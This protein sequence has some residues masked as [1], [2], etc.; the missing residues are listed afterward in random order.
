[1]GFECSAS[2]VVSHSM[3]QSNKYQTA[4]TNY[5]MRVAE[6]RL[7]SLLLAKKLAVADPLTC[8]TLRAV[9][10]RAGKT[11]AEMAALVPSLLHDA[12]Y[13]VA[14]VAAELGLTVRALLRA[15]TRC[16]C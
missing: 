10:E 12:L 15:R 2:F 1:V 4:A 16:R 6:C 3:V 8:L 7:A 11:V 14:E 9:Q 5:N 13:T